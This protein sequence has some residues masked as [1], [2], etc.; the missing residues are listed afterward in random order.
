M[1]NNDSLPRECVNFVEACRIAKHIHLFSVMLM[2]LFAFILVFVVWLAPDYKAPFGIALGCAGA[3]SM[4][5]M[6]AGSSVWAWAE[7]CYKKWFDAETAAAAAVEFRTLINHGKHSKKHLEALLHFE[8]L[9]KKY[10]AHV[11][12]TQYQV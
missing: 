3:V 5:G 10:S 4:F 2:P 9:Y 11:L 12:R 1:K 7:S 8:E 6:M